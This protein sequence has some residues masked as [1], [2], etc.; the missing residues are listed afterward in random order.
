M[1]PSAGCVCTSGSRSRGFHRRSTGIPCAPAGTR[2][3]AGRARRGV[4]SRSGRGRSWGSG[5]GCGCGPSV[6]PTGAR[7]CRNGVPGCAGRCSGTARCGW[8][9]AWAWRVLSGGDRVHG[10]GGGGGP[11]GAVGCRAC[12]LRRGAAHDACDEQDRL[13]VD[14][15]LVAAVAG[16]RAELDAA[17]VAAPVPGLAVRA[18]GAFPVRGAF[19]DQDA[20]AMGPLAAEAVVALRAAVHEL[21][22]GVAVLQGVVPHAEERVLEEQDVRPGA[23][24]GE[25]NEGHAH[26]ASLPSP[27]AASSWAASRA[28][29]AWRP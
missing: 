2:W 16:L 1:L 10:G 19:P 18:A 4:A 20:V 13:F 24:P 8:W 5:A 15:L 26:A 23:G 6:R 21:Y 7:R 3:A 12:A 27:P 25:S 14:H 22:A 9:R 29:T 11:A 28:A 17:P